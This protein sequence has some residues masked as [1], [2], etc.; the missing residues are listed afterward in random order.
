MLIMTDARHITTILGELNE[1]C[2]QYNLKINS[3]KSGIFCN[4][5]HKQLDNILQ[6]NLLNIPILKTYNYLG[7]NIDNFG[8]I[9]PHL[10]FLR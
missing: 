5:N 2:A 3:K 9:N 6:T 8:T 4:R 7:I 10:T 1:L